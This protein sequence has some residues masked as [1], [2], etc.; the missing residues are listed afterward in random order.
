MAPFY[1]LYFIF[2]CCNHVLTSSTILTTTHNYHRYG[3][4]CIGDDRFCAES[5]SS[6]IHFFSVACTSCKC[7]VRVDPPTID[8]LFT[9]YTDSTLMWDDV[10]TIRYSASNGVKFV[11]ILLYA[12][13]PTAANTVT[14]IRP[15]AISTPNTGQYEWTVPRISPRDDYVVVLFHAPRSGESAAPTHRNT[16]VFG[17]AAPTTEPCP[18]GEVNEATGSPP[19]LKC[20]PGSYSFNSTTCVRCPENST[21]VFPGAAEIDDCDVLA[22]HALYSFKPFPQHYL[23]GSNGAGIFLEDSDHKTPEECARACLDDAGCKSFDAGVIDQHQAGD[24]FLSYDDRETIFP[25]YFREVS[26]L[27]Y[28]ERIEA[29]RPRAADTTYIKHSGCHLTER[30]DGGIFQN[31]YTTETCAQLCLNDICC[32]SF[33]SGKIEGESIGHCFL[34]YHT[35]HDLSDP[36]DFVCDPVYELDYY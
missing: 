12:M 23:A 7:D 16:G 13:H 34:S 24:C 14:Y 27:S 32:K 1:I 3:S 17:I 21:S 22:D 19:C 6:G 26:Q 15:I 8:F 2:Y 29:P 31:T 35:R 25:G 9:P 4:K 30:D 33:D 36:N 20:D 28:Y 5:T 10:F 11:H 18:P